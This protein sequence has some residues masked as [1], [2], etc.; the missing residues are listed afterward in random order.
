[1][2]YLLKEDYGVRTAKNQIIFLHEISAMK[3]IKVLMVSII[4]Y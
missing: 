1:M 3:F 2:K 4:N